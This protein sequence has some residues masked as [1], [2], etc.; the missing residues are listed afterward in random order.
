MFFI[1]VAERPTV[2]P[3]WVDDTFSQVE[4]LVYSGDAAGLAA[5]VARLTA[6]RTI[7]ATSEQPF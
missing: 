6:E 5:L 1:L 4:D 3:A 7:S 2:A